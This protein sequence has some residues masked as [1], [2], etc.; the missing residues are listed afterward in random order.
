MASQCLVI[1]AFYQ[2]LIRRSGLIHKEHAVYSCACDTN[3]KS[4]DW[5]PVWCH[6]LTYRPPCNAHRPP[7]PTGFCGVD[8]SVQDDQ[9]SLSLAV[10]ASYYC[11]LFCAQS[12]S[13]PNLALITQCNNCLL[14]LAINLDLD[15]KKHEYL[16]II[17]RL[18]QIAAHLLVLQVAR[19]WVMCRNCT[20]RLKRLQCAFQT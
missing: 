9:Y 18:P 2:D 8:L 4:E 5:G 1:I 16:F 6:L 13:K 12:L 14:Q 10:N 11:N 15:Y 3:L 20:V 19:R 7:I 17:K